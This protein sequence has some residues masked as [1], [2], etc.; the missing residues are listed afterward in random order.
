ML[1]Q[2][3]EKDGRA[4]AF[5]AIWEMPPRLGR[6]R[7][8]GRRQPRMGWQSWGI[9]LLQMAKRWGDSERHLMTQIE[10]IGF[11]PVPMENELCDHC[12]AL[13]RLSAPHFRGRRVN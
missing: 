11:T 8:G 9:F 12:Q 1:G 6:G 4:G 3:G 7:G 13:N 10:P 2:E 5:A